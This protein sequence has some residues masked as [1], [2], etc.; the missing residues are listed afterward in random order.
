MRVTFGSA[1]DLATSLLASTGMP[2]P[3][4]RRTAW[5][6]VA[7]DS[8]GRGS[9]GLLRLPYYLARLAAGGANPRAELTTVRDRPG[10]LSLDG[11]NGLGHWQVWHAAEQAAQRAA[12]S[13]LAAVSVGNSGHCGAL[14]LYLL[15]LVES[16]LVGMVFSH[17]PAV[18]PPWGGNSPITSTSP[19]AMGFPVSPRPAIV[20]MACSAVARG[21]IA[22]AANAGTE[23]PEGWALDR[24][25]RP[26]TDPAQAL[27]GMLAPMGGAK[28]FALALAV[29]ALTAGM[30]GPRLST[31]VADPLDPNASGQP[32]SIAHLVVAI[33]PAA[34]DVDGR[35]TERMQELAA[36][37]E[38]AGGRLPGGG[39]PLPSELSD[40]SELTLADHTADQLRE[41]AAARGVTTP[42]G[43]SR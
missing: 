21:K 2:E 19:L 27:Q 8:W 39:H 1:T 23:L 43:W 29:E 36:S 31:A 24:E 20:D 30:I 6:L 25:G 7:A 37:I 35:A 15:P 13:G 11:D 32:Q 18:I 42:P 17:G 26:T 4:A 41:A 38:T 22:Q 12:S 14:G 16:G 28:G 33:D 9:H 10:T 3:A 40:E 5:A 34:L